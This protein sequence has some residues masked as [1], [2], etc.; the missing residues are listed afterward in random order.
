VVRGYDATLGVLLLMRSFRRPPLGRLSHLL[1]KP[2]YDGTY[3]V[4]QPQN[5]DVSP[6]NPILVLVTSGRCRS[7]C[8]S[9]REVEWTQ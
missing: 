7:R 1:S 3:P 5:P 4:N 8:R 6:F 9:T 2:N